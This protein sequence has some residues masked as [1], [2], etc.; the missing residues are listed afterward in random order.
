[1]LSIASDKQHFVEVSGQVN[2]QGTFHPW[3]WAI[4]GHPFPSATWGPSLSGQWFPK[5]RLLT[6]ALRTEE[7]LTRGMQ[8]PSPAGPGIMRPRP[9][10]HEAPQL[11]R[12]YTCLRCSLFW[13]AGKWSADI[14]DSLWLHLSSEAASSTCYPKPQAQIDLLFHLQNTHSIRPK[15]RGRFS[16]PCLLFPD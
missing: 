8:H 9:L 5:R 14:M 4:L 16:L 6:R 13:Q 3:D 11:T 2:F 12:E 1:M 10:L 15:M 7:A